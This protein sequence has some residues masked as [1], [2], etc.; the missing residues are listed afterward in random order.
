MPPKAAVNPPPGFAG[1]HII[2]HVAGQR[3]IAG[4]DTVSVPN[5]TTNI[6]LAIW[7]GNGLPADV[8]VSCRF[9]EIDY[10]PF[11][12]EGFPDGSPIRHGVYVSREPTRFTL[13]QASSSPEFAPGCCPRHSGL[14]TAE[15]N[16]ASLP[17]E[18]T[19]LRDMELSL[20][21]TYYLLGDTTKN[22]TELKYRITVKKATEQKL[23][24]PSQ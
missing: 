12:Q 5:A 18:W 15:Y 23:E 17:K 16:L 4:Q 14:A 13:L 19:E 6:P 10:T 24:N 1:L 3:V 9:T 22:M 20:E 11:P 7:V 2:P 21:L 8:F